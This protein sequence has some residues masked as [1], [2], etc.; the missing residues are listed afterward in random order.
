MNRHLK[1][2]ALSMLLASCFWWL[3]PSDLEA[4]ISIGGGLT[5]ERTVRPGEICQGVVTVINT[6][7]EAQ[8]VMIY[9]TDYRFTCEGDYHYDEPGSNPH[10]NAPWVAFSPHAVSVPAGGTADVGYT[11]SVPQAEDLVGT[12]W[13]ILMIELGGGPAEHA[14]D[15]TTGNIRLGINQIVRYGV[16]IVTHVGDTGER[17]L[18]FL[19]TR[20]LRAGDGRVLEIDIANSGQCWLRPLVWAE[21]YDDNGEFIGRFDGGKLRIYPATSVRYTIDLTEVPSGRYKAVVVADCGADD[22]FGATYLLILE[23][24]D[25]FTIH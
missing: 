22:V 4:G 3:L 13:S 16:Q 7:Q 8:E 10:S 6:G 25:R 1:A 5:H 24:E 14:A 17:N 2:M 20:L 12:Y 19:D 11:I 15:K 18:D 9:Q 21:L 23:H